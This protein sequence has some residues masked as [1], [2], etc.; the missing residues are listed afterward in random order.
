MLA[1][2]NRKMSVIADLDLIAV[3]QRRS[4]RSGSLPV[5]ECPVRRIFVDDP[6]PVAVAIN[7]RVQAGQSVVVETMIG[8][9]A[10]AESGS[11]ALDPDLAGSFGRRVCK[12]NFR[13][14]KLR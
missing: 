3:S 5:D 2:M 4:R 8:I 13:H 1:E 7:G 6:D 14:N 11:L 12:G 10:A 9:A